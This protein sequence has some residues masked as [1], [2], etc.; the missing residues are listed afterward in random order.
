MHEDKWR[1]SSSKVPL[2]AFPRLLGDGRRAA[3][4]A[5]EGADLGSALALL[6]LALIF[7]FIIVPVGAVHRLSH[8]GCVRSKDKC[9]HEYKTHA[10]QKLDIV[11]KK[12][13]KKNS[14]IL[15][16]ISSFT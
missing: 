3:A 4:A 10:Q 8:P 13:K 6:P 12:K 5:G 2:L 11:D 14:F 15:Q 9:A 7:M 1:S 16:L